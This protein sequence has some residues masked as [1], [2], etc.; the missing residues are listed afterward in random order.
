[1]NKTSESKS[2]LPLEGTKVEGLTSNFML[3]GGV[4]VIRVVGMV[5]GFDNSWETEEGSW[6]ESDE[7]R[8]SRSGEVGSVGV[9]GVIGVVW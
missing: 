5:I 1:M 8:S 3:A 7:S 4:S 6:G 2:E 9:I